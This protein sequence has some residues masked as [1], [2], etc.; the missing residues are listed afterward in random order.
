MHDP[1]SFKPFSEHSHIVAL[2]TTGNVYL[3]ESLKNMGGRDAI[4]DSP[5]KKYVPPWF[6]KSLALTRCR[7]DVITLQNPHAPMEPPKAIPPSKS[8]NAVI[9][10]PIAAM[11]KSSVSAC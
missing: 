9:K 11:T 1:I 3:A 7:S 8:K 6:L 10:P 5:F 4:D 2:A